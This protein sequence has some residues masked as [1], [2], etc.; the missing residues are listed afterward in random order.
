[1]STLS[2]IVILIF[3]IQTC[4]AQYE[5]LRDYFIFPLKPGNKASLSGS[6]GELRGNHF[7]SGIDIRT[8]GKVNLPILAAA[9]GY[10]SRINISQ[11]GYGKAIYIQH[12]NGY[13]SVY[14]HLNSFGDKIEKYV[15]NAQYKNKSF[16]IKLYPKSGDLP[17]MS[18]EIIAYSGN[19]GGSQ[20]PHLHFEVRN[21]KS[22]PINPL[23]SSFPEL[24]DTI[25]PTL[26]ALT[27]APLNDQTII[28]NT[29][30]INYLKIP[31]RSYYKVKP[32]IY[33]LGKIG[34]GLDVYDK[35]NGAPN[36]NGIS[37]IRVY[38]NGSLNYSCNIERFSF[39]QSKYI[40][41]HLE[42]SSYKLAQIPAHR[43]YI[44][45]TNPLP[46]Y[47]RNLKG[48]ITVNKGEKKDIT[49]EAFDFYG[50]KS[51]IE[52]TILGSL[53]KNPRIHAL[54]Q[55]GQPLSTIKSGMNQNFITDS[56]RIYF[57]TNSLFESMDL[58]LIH[59]ADTFNLQM[60]TAPLKGKITVGLK[61][62]IPYSLRD[63]TKVYSYNSKKKS[64]YNEGG[65]WNDD[66]IEFKTKSF[67]KYLCIPDTEKPIFSNPKHNNNSFHISIKD[68]LSGV[69]KYKAQLNGQWVLL[70]YYPN[71][72]SFNVLT[73]NNTPLKGE[74]IIDVWDD[75]SNHNTYKTTLK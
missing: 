11:T 51:K 29:S 5:E 15:R 67:N 26:K 72:N 53:D 21:N 65:I 75:V 1:M 38:E 39:P 54:K 59:I 28:N 47:D 70:E 61:P 6:F 33:A 73:L 62:N 45:S 48:S 50:N 74:L 19:T 63:K 20:A 57:S 9:G 60:N 37:K 18:G 10:V 40:K 7:H 3:S 49:I 55:Q 69:S 14:A 35:G 27:L 16:T 52:F 13:T 44:K 41:T 2:K 56:C 46:F 71:D 58:E 31:N 30:Q 32:T 22:E 17:I 25:P 64:Y 23:F 12:P 42:Y 4:F 68:N 66:F 36:K 24:K 34:L 8:Y 43:C